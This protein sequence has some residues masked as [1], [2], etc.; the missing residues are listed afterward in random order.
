MSE[1]LIHPPRTILE[2]WKGLPEGTLCQIINDELIMSPSPITIHQIITGEIY[3]EIALH[4]KKAKL[5]KI[6]IA[7]YDVHFSNKNILQ[8]DIAFIRNENRNKIKEN[9]LFGAPDIVIEILS[10]STS[11]LDYDDKKLIYERYGVQEYFIV[12]P[13][14]KMV[15]SFFLN[16]GEYEVQEITESKIQSLVLNT[17]IN[18]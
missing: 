5:G 3:V 9:G 18:F 1:I 10:P 2:V 8:P 16:N 12:E 7:P 14:S 15:N 6:F 13:N 4:L 17:E 11:H